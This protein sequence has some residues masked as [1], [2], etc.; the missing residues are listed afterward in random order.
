MDCII[1]FFLVFHILCFEDDYD[2]HDG[3][4]NEQDCDDDH[5]YHNHHHHCKNWLV[6]IFKIV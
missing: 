2:N 5:H 4:D 6:W 3:D 1:S